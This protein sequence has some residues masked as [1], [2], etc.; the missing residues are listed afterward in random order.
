MSR[1]RARQYDPTIPAHIDQRALPKGAYWHRRDRFWYT[2][3][4]PARKFHRL[5]NASATVAQLHQQLDELANGPR[6]TIEWLHAQ[7][8]DSAKWKTL[9][10][11]TRDDYAACLRTLKAT[12]TRH[13]PFASLQVDRLTRPVLQRLVDRIGE[14]R[15]A[16]ANHVARYLGRLIKWGMQRGRCAER[17]NPAHGL[18]LAKE[19]GECKVPSV[20]TMNAVLAF[21]R[22]RGA[23]KAHSRG[24][25][26]PYLWIVIVLAYRLRLRGIEVLTLTDA[27]E[28]AAGVRTNRRKGSR[29]NV[30]R[31]ADAVEDAWLAAWE[32]RDAIWTRTGQPVPLK[33][34]DRLLLVNEKGLPIQRSSLD[35]AWRRLMESA[36][37]AGVIAAD[38][39]FTP[40]GLKHRGITDTKG[41]KQPA[42]GHVDPRMLLTYDHE[43][44]EVDAAGD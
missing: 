17:T 27:A 10:E 13:G 38:E 31:W 4:G 32:L 24:S 43:V 20:L 7:F 18:E 39:W 2:L 9:A 33:A 8:E 29:D 3:L 16:M 41:A 5:G 40:H 1:G 6:G 25:V 21:A 12:R 28:A 34:E 44:P 42:S 11:A 19:L 26:A 30:T 36:I 14:D 37:A 23:L 15:P 35:S 22:E